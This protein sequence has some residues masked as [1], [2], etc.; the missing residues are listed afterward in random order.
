MR[1]TISGNSKRRSIPTD[2]DHWVAYMSMVNVGM[3]LLA[4]C[5]HVPDLLQLKRAKCI[6][7]AMETRA[8]P[9]WSEPDLRGRARWITVGL[10]LLAA[11][12]FALSVQTAWWSISEVTIGPFGSRHCFGGECT[13]TGFAWLGEHDFF[14][15]AAVATRAGGYIAMF[16]YVFVAARVAAKRVPTLMGRAG[17][18]AILTATAAAITFFVKF[19]GGVG[20]PTLG[21][22]PLLF[23][24]GVVS[25]V[26]AS[27]LVQRARR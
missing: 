17:I 11:S 25:G 5:E 6:W 26:T 13:S 12:M 16:V 14:M 18:V 3:R 9:S 1:R 10:A 8:N 21:V 2:R 15:R 24:I 22:G 7:P 27:L 23:A 19:P 4:A 20:E